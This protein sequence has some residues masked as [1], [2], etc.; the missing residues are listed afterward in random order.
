MFF[1]PLAVVTEPPRAVA[2]MVGTDTVEI[3]MVAI[4]TAVET[5]TEADMAAP[6]A[7]VVAVATGADHLVRTIGAAAVVVTGGPAPDLTLHVSK[8]PK[9]IFTSSDNIPYDV[10]TISR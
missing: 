5:G 10:F 1:F 2:A 4:V 3:D 9:M 8:P 7:M 6:G